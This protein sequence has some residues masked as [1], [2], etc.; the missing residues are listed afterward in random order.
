MTDDLF[1]QLGLTQD[2]LGPTWY[3]RFN[4][5]GIP[6]RVIFGLRP[7]IG[8]DHIVTHSSGLF[9]FHP[10]G[11]L[12]L[13]VAEGEPEVPGWTEVHDL[14]AFMPEEPGRW[15]LRRGAVD[16]LGA[17]NISHWRLSPLVIHETPLSWL[18]TAATG[19][20]I[21][22]WAFDPLA[23]LVGAGQLLLET[24]ALKRRIEDRF[25]EAALAPFSITDIE[26]A[27]HV[28]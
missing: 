20:C 22:D 18:Q 28:A 21:V 15:W 10:E 1:G 13:I 12:A 5:L 7:L 17:S 16:L 3:T 25:T 26:E 2:L 4:K 11:D 19:I 8:V 6:D 9:E 14:L 23:R 24:P 27:R